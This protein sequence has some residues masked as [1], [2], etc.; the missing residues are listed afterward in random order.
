MEK[1]KPN[2]FLVHIDSAYLHAAEISASIELY[3]LSKHAA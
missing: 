3:F 2:D 1:G